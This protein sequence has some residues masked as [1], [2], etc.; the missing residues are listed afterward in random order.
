MRRLLICFALAAC[1][2]HDPGGIDTLIGAPCTSN[3]QCDHTCYQGPEF[4]SGFCSEPCISDRDCPSDAVC[5][6]AQGGMCA[7]EC[8]PFDCGRLGG[9][10]SCQDKDQPGGGKATV[11]IGG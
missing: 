3:G 1:H 9:G 2:G 7:Y 10:S 8:P 11:C 6:I 4:P 5:I